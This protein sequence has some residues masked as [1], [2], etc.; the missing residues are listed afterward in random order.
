MI[1]KFII[2]ITNHKSLITILAIATILRFWN[3]SINP[4]HLTSDEAALGYN[5]Y[6]ILKTGHDEHGVFMPIVFESFGDWKPGLY[7]YLTVPFV[8]LFGLNEFSTRFVG[9]TSGVIAVFVLYLVVKKLFE[10]YRWN[11]SIALFSAL[12]LALSPW[13]LQFTRGAWESGVA[14]TFVLLGIYYFLKGLENTKNL[15][16]SVIYFVLTSWTYQGAKLSTAI[17]VVGLLLVYKSNLWKIQKKVIAKCLLLSFVLGLPI[18]ITFFQGKVGRLEVYSLFSYPRPQSVVEE[19]ANQDTTNSKILFTLYHS[20]PLNYSIGLISRWMS[21]YSGRF[22]FIEGDWTNKRHGVPDMGELLFIDSIFLLLGIIFAS[23]QGANKPFLFLWYLLIFSP[24]PAALSRDSIHPVR[25]LYLLI[26]LTILISLGAVYLIQLVKGN[27]IFRFGV[28]SIISFLYLLNYVYYLDQYWVHAPY[29]NS[30]SWQYGYKQIVE[31]IKPIQKKYSEIVVQQSYD[32]PYIYFLFYKKYDPKN[33]QQQSLSNVETNKFG[34]VSLVTK[35]DN[36]IFREPN[37]SGDQ[38]LENR[39]FVF[40]SIKVTK[41]E[42]DDQKRYKIL[43][44][45]KYLNG[46]TA[47][48]FIEPITK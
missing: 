20:E 23:K 5:A 13:H 16:L 42:I 47:F 11:K 45:I 37:W 33:Y 6:S 48:R 25:S 26:P 34:D 32:Q 8:A 3:L 35:I 12:S 40:D 38:W 29:L 43:D 19:I 22:L 41:K 9:A 27:K 36:I 30:Q 1:K 14:L 24:L 7:V 4:P 17:V 18:L 31:Y 2:L 21:H 46:H 28:F 39:L 15:Y 10:E 44:E